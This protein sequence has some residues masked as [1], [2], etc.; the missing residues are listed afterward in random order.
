MTP[1]VADSFQSTHAPAVRWKYLVAADIVHLVAAGIVLD[2]LLFRGIDIHWLLR[3]SLI[4]VLFFAVLR[5]H[6]WVILLAIQ[7]SFLLREPARTELSADIESFSICVAVLLLVAYACSLR[8]TRRQLQFW[9]GSG[10]QTLLSGQHL[11]AEASSASELSEPHKPARAG[12]LLAMQLLMPIAVALVAMLIF[13]QLPVSRSGRE[14]WWQRSVADRF[15]LW[16]GPTVLTLAIGLLVI[17][18]QLD[19]RQI[20]PAQARLVLRSTFLSSHYRDLKM[21][22]ARSL[23][24]ARH[25]ASQAEAGSTAPT[26]TIRSAPA[27]SSTNA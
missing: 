24:A 20:T 26:Q 15:T 23:K 27:P 19:W 12:R 1:T 25:P 13:M 18:W 14:Q 3:W 9:L 7:L 2:F 10:L 4:G 5:A 21:I 8:T 11:Q 6:A 22:V 17:V 16:P